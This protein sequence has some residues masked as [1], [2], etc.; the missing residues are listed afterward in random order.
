[1]GGLIDDLKKLLRIGRSTG[2]SGNSTGAGTGGS[3]GGD[4]KRPVIRR[5]NTLAVIAAA[6]ILLIVLANTFSAGKTDIP[7]GT[8]DIGRQETGQEVTGSGVTGG[9]S[10]S[11][12]ITELENLLAGRLEKM[13]VQIEG[14]GETRVTVN[15]ASTT[16]K[17]Y[18]INTST[19]KRN[20][21]E[22]DQKGGNR[23]IT[24]INEDGQMVL[25]RESQGSRELPVVV[26]EIK[27]EVKGVIVVAKGA[28]DPEI[29]SDLMNAVQVYLDVPL[30]RV[31]VLPMER[32]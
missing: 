28:E 13:L 20:T 23:T 21:L 17:D 30:Y 27:P 15:L 25:I 32:R 1:M 10:S 2:E 12:D 19:N 29:R 18:A 11:G 3:S 7:G 8:A 16:E 6:G 26:K 14:V 31:I 22:K 9:Y 24:E 4:G 5:L